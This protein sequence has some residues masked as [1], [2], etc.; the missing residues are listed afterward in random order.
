M[1]KEKKRTIFLASHPQEVHPHRPKPLIGVIKT[2]RRRV[3]FPREGE[4]EQPKK[5]H[6]EEEKGEPHNRRVVVGRCHVRPQ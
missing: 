1:R 3:A 2:G 5:T 4:K 6:T